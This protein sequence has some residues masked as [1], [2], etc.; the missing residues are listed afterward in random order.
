MVEVIDLDIER[1]QVF[2][3]QK[4]LAALGRVQVAHD[5]LRQWRGMI[6]QAIAIL[7]ILLEIGHRLAIGD[8][9][10]GRQHGLAQADETLNDK[11]RVKTDS[12]T[13]SAVSPSGTSKWGR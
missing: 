9:A 10:V 2:L 13:I 12:G 6:Q 11:P 3:G 5:D 4:R 7:L 8:D 1:N